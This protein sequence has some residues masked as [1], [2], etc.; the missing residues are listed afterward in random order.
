MIDASWAR[1]TISD[2]AGPWTSIEAT[3]V[4]PGRALVAENCQYTQGQVATRLGYGVAFATV[5]IASALYNWISSLGNYLVS[6]LPS[7]GVRAFKVSD[8]SPTRATLASMTTGVACSF[9]PSG[10][11]MYVA[12]FDANGD[13]VGAAKVI[14][15]KSS[16][17]SADSCFEPPMTYTPAAISEPGTGLIT[18]GAHRVGYVVQTRSGYSCRPSPDSGVGTPGPST[19]VPITFTAAGSKNARIVLNPT[20]WPTAAASVSIVMSPVFN[21]GLYVYVPG[22]TATVVGGTN[23]PQTITWSISDED[24]VNTGV[25]ATDLL[26]QMSQTTAGVAPFNPS[27]VEPYGD[28]LCYVT[29]TTDP[30]GNAIG[31]VYAS[32]RNAYQSL[33]ADQHLVM[34]PGQLNVTTVKAMRGILYLFGPNYTY[35]VHDTTTKPIEWPLASLIDGRRGAGSVRSVAVSPTGTYMWVASEAGLYLFDGS[36]YPALPVSFLN[37]DIWALINWSAGACVQVVDDPA[38]KRVT[39]MAPLG[40]ATTPSHM[41]VWDYTRGLSF[42]KVSFSK[43]SLS[44]YA[45]GSMA[46]VRNDLSGST[47]PAHVELWLGSSAAAPIMRQKVATEP[48]PWR[49]GSA[50]I[51]WVYETGMLPADAPFQLLRHHGGFLRVQGAGTLAITAKHL[52]ASWS[53]TMSPVTLALLPG[54]EAQRWL[55]RVGERVSLRFATSAV[56]SHCTLSNLEYFY[57]PFARER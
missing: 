45:L 35:A 52:D 29:T 38:Q 39:V 20:T 40:S 51:A 54:A 16:T 22:A 30:N 8:A 14:T 15:Y 17:F 41:L 49:D 5:E 23:D 25:E 3:D 31:V 10:P 33:S 24:L 36:G 37:S 1:L 12:G 55:Y 57:S 56:D 48:E 2:F 44:G 26:M 46:L 27:V 6:F 18:V 7:T 11:R 28:R 19:F 32:E 47:N 4:P 50:A 43:D 9:A 34:L 42:D 21:P 13:A 53:Q